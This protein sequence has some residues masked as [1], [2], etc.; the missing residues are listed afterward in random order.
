V[1]YGYMIGTAI[2]GVFVLLGLVAFVWGMAIKPRWRNRMD[3]SMWSFDFETG[4][5]MKW[6][7]AAVAVV[8]FGIWLGV[9]FPPF[10]SKYHS[11]R[12]VSGTVTAIGT[13]LLG[14]DKSTTQEIV[15]T[16]GGQDYRCDDTRCSL[17]KVGDVVSMQCIGVFELHGVSGYRCNFVSDR[18]AQP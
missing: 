8:S 14:Q 4:F 13:R 3:G 11:Y 2:A 10:E 17:V 9:A 5:W 12:P 1:T 16:V 6:A 7:G 15:F 18:R